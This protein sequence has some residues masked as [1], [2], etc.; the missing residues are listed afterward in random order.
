MSK[1][2][3]IK[4]YKYKDNNKREIIVTIIRREWFVNM[5]VTRL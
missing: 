5:T 2:K 1:K 3:K 4:S